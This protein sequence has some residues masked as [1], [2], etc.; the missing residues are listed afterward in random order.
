M[1]ELH[2]H[3]DFKPKSKPAYIITVKDRFVRKIFSFKCKEKIGTS[4]KV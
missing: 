1:P 2:Y 4:I 3:E